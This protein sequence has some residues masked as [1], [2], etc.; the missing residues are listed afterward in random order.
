VVASALLAVVLALLAA[1]PESVTLNAER[2]VVTYGD[3]VRLSVV[4]EPP[5]EHVSVVGLPYDGGSYPSEAVPDEAG[6]WIVDDRPSITTQYRARA[7]AIDGAEAPVVMVRPRVHLVVISARRGRFY[8]RAES[9]LSYRARSAWVQP[10]TPRGWSPVTR[11]RLG[12]RSAVRFSAPLPD[13][14][15]RVRV[16][17]EPIPGYARGISRIAVI[18]R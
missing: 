1:E 14:R 11:V 13:G 10:R 3:S 15:S 18:R 5:T 2:S 6:R 7:G 17:V 9:L 4:V 8:V 12:P 16:V